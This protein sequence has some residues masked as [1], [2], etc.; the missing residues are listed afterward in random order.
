VSAPDGATE[1]LA[2][3]R[4]RI[5]ERLSGVVRTTAV[6]SGKG[7]V[8]K[9]AVAV[10]L[11]L[12][13]ARRGSRV[14]LLD[15]DFQG[16]SVAKMLGLRGQPLRVAPDGLRPARGPCEL[17]VQ[18]LD[19]F[20]Q[21]AQALALE[22]D[23]GEGA[24]LRSALEEAVLADL[25]GGTVWGE[26]D[27]L[28]IDLPPGADRLPALVR[29][30]PGL[31]GGV[32]VTIPTEVALLAVERSVRRAH[33]LAIPLIGLVA[34]MA[35]AVCAACGAESPLFQEAPVE[36]FARESDLPLLA[37]IPFDPRIAAAAD[38]GR[39]FVELGGPASPAARAF[40]QLAARVA[41]FEPSGSTDDAAPAQ[42]GRRP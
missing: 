24:P 8:G 38:A 7:G 19:F 12:S 9:S 40:D 13:L 6:L 5:R 20:L 41:S 30:V 11:A 23:G 3:V 27:H 10:N 34:N 28:V 42:E 2:S 16:P 1:D 17:R 18:S 22:G 37:R 39:P 4:E 36:R 31:T 15:A 32:A 14:A 29:L 26:L 35:G 21:G 25:L 33:E